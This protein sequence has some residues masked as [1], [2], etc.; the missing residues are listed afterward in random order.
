MDIQFLSEDSYS[1][2]NYITKYMTKA[3]KSNLK[4]MDFKDLSKSTFQN[5]SKFAY[6]CLKSREMGA[7]EAADRILHNHGQMWRSS[8]TFVW[9]QT[10]PASQRSRVMKNIKTLE[11]QV[12]DNDDVFYPDLCV[13]DCFSSCSLVLRSCF[14][15][16]PSS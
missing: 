13:M 1:I 12:P 4:F 16:L 7:H 15:P 14:S 10:T 9:V 5:L 2:C 3:E 8:E 6:S 11:K